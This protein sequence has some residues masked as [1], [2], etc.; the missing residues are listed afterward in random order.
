MNLPKDEE[1]EYGKLTV[2]QLKERLAAIGAKLGGRKKELIKR[3]ILYELN[4]NFGHEPV[5][6]VPDERMKTSNDTTYKDL[7]AGCPLPASTQVSLLSFLKWYHDS[8]TI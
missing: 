8:S 5:D 6:Y 1:V 2:K 3:L 4:A 7:H